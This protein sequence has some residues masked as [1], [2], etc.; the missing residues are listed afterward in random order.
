MSEY[1][2]AKKREDH[3]RDVWWKCPHCGETILTVNKDAHLKNRHPPEPKSISFSLSKETYDFI[4]SF[5]RK[6]NTDE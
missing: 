3:I 4:Q 6:A 2:K 1:E 5:K